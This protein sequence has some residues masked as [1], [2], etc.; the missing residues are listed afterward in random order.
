MHVD[1]YWHH[2]EMEPPIAREITEL[3]VSHAAQRLIQPKRQAG[4]TP[5]PGAATSLRSQRAVREAT[6]TST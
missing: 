5:G 2:W 4:E 1:L 3:I 6:L